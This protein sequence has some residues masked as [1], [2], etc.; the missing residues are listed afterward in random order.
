MQ[1]QETW[2]LHRRTLDEMELIS[3]R[4]YVSPYHLAVV[5]CALG[6]KEEALDLLEKA[7]ETGDAQDPVDGSR[8]G[9]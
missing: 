8:S 6:R 7:Y 5:N 1:R 9:T 2:K 3:A 4:R